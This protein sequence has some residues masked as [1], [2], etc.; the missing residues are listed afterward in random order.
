MKIN[1]A[2]KLLP[3]FKFLQ[4]LLFLMVLWAMFFAVPMQSF[5][6]KN[7]IEQKNNI[8]NIKDSSEATG[9]AG[10][11][12][13]ESGIFTKEQDSAYKQDMRLS[14]PYLFM[15]KKSLDASEFQWNLWLKNMQ[16]APNIILSNSFEKMPEGIL[17]PTLEEIV[18]HRI[19]VIQALSIPTAYTFD[20]SGLRIDLRKVGTFLGILEDVS[21]V[22]SY[23]VPFTA[24]VEIVIYSV[25]AKII[26]TI[27][28]G[29]QR[30][31]NHKITWNGKDDNG[32]KV[33]YGDYIA[34]VRI[35]QERF[36]RKRIVID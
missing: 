24:D 34:E 14:L 6:Q 9:T 33:P 18:Q 29:T 10:S 5:E 16:N 35:G 4:N 20:P 13:T 23:N 31:G 21:P 12:E 27:F 19:N 17:N 8:T 26:A 36:Y 7:Q 32:K 25:N 30:Q 11:Y 15:T 2:N 1:I 22:I 28:R 3:N